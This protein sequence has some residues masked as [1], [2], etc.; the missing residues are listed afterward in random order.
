MTQQLKKKK[1]M[2]ER[3]RREE[4]N[5]NK[6]KKK[7]KWTNGRIFFDSGARCSSSHQF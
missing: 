1:K 7:R 2:R 4:K 3:G 5:K 6:N